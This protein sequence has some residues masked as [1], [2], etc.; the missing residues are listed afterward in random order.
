M[1]HNPDSIVVDRHQNEGLV[2]AVTGFPIRSNFLAPLALSSTA[3]QL[4]LSSLRIYSL[5]DR[6]LCGIRVERRSSLKTGHIFGI[7]H[8]LGCS[9]WH[10]RSRIFML[11][12]V[13]EIFTGINCLMASE[14]AVGP[15]YQ[16]A[17]PPRLSSL[18]AMTLLA[19]TTRPEHYH[20]SQIRW[21]RWRYGGRNI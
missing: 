5:D 9:G 21:L 18:S 13:W 16:L 11:P 2:I 4:W 3:A 14:E 6:L 12:E 1:T 19:Q 15:A 20:N 10:I 8:S 17:P 7:N